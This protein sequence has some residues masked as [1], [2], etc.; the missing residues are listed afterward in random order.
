MEI[1]FNKKEVEAMLVDKVIGM[2]GATAD[3]T[4]VADI[5]SYGGFKATVTI[6]AP[7]ADSGDAE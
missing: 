2:I 5:G 7:V 4:V 3:K 1:T 6:S